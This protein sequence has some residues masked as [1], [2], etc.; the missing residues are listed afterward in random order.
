MF[1]TRAFFEFAYEANPFEVVC[2]ES[3]SCGTTRPD[4]CAIDVPTFFHLSGE[5]DVDFCGA[6]ALVGYAEAH[7]CCYGEYAGDEGEQEKSEFMSHLVV[8]VG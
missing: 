4:V 5:N 3:S 1:Q 2:A 8:F 6:D 7:L